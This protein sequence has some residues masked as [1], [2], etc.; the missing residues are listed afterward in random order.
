[1]ASVMAERII[2][3]DA[4]GQGIKSYYQAKIDSL[5]IVNQDRTR[6]LRRLAAQRN[7]LNS[8]GRRRAY[9]FCIGFW[10]SLSDT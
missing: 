5:E 8:Q 1:M 9:L 6:N 7:E 2:K 10:V 3:E 4:K